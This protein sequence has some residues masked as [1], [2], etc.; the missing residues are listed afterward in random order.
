MHKLGGE[1]QNLLMIFIPLILASLFAIYWILRTR[2]VL[3][4]IISIGMIM[5]FVVVMASSGAIKTM[6]LFVYMGFVSLAFG[7]AF[8]AKGKILRERIIIAMMSASIL[9]YWIWALNHWHGNAVILA[10]LTLI[11]GTMGII[12]KAKLRNELGFLVI[13]AADAISIILEKI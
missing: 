10:F 2:Q 12:F 8:I 5:G 1:K 6:G 9:V 3:P 4:A 11:V 13:L 7:Y